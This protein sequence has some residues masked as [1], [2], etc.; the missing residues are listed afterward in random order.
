[1][2]NVRITLVLTLAAS[3][4][5][6]A[7]GGAASP[8]G[9]GGTG[10]NSGTP[11]PSVAVNGAYTG[12][13]TVSGQAATP[14]LGAL[15]ATSAGYFADSNGFVYILPAIPSSGTVSGTVTGYAPPGQ[16]FSS[17]KTVQTFTVTGAATG[18]TG[19]AISGTIAG[20]GINATFTLAS[21]PIAASATLAG[22]AG[23]YTGFYT[24]ST[25][26]T[27]S[28]SLSSAGAIT[29]FDSFGCSITGTLATAADGLFTITGNSSGNGCASDFTGMGFAATSDL[30]NAFSGAAGTYVYVGASNASSA[31]AAELKHQ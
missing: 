26:A 27:L 19:S 15:S 3:F 12:S 6:G 10:G 8:A 14:V 25:Q 20:G 28:L 13:Y 30:A 16:A 9:S 17:G 23:S 4:W 29:G 1:M 24:G 5:L 21:K 7:C 18:A 22:L 11:P 31:F 2:R